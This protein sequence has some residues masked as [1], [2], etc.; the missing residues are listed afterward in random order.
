[1]YGSKCAKIKL[2][3]ESFSRRLFRGIL[4]RPKWRSQ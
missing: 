4:G 1:M 3:T 2:R